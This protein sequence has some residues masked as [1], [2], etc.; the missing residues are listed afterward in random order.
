MEGPDALRAHMDVSEPVSIDDNDLVPT[1]FSLGGEH[2]ESSYGEHV[3]PEPVSEEVYFALTDEEKRE[4]PRDAL[5]RPFG[6]WTWSNE[7]WNRYHRENPR[8]PN[9]GP[10]RERLEVNP[11]G[12]CRNRA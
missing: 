7:A 10:P 2:H 5:G 9:A 8:T 4:V 6:Y 12:F 11:E 3:E 1:D